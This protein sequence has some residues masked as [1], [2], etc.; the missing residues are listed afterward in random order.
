M[1]IVGRSHLRASCSLSFCC[2]T[3]SC[4][5][6][7]S[8]R[9]CVVARSSSCLPA[10]RRARLGC[11]GSDRPARPAAP[12]KEEQQQPRGAR[13]G[14]ER[15]TTGER[16]EE[17]RVRWERGEGEKRK[18]ECF[19]LRSETSHGLS[20]RDDSIGAALHTSYASAHD[21]C[22]SP[23]CLHLLP[24]LFPPLLPP[25]F[26]P[27][28]SARPARDSQGRGASPLKARR[29]G[30]DETRRRRIQADPTSPTS[31]QLRPNRSS[32]PATTK[33]THI[34]TTNARTSEHDR[35][36]RTNHVGHRPTRRV[37]PDWRN[38]RTGAGTVSGSKAPR[39]NGAIRRCVSA[40][41]NNALHTHTLDTIL[42]AMLC[43][44]CCH[45]RVLMIDFVGFRRLSHLHLL[46]LV[47][48]PN[49][50][51]YV[52]GGDTAR[53]LSDKIRMQCHAMC[54]H[55]PRWCLLPSSLRSDVSPLTIPFSLVCLALPRFRLRRMV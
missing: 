27:V 46:L 35:V 47:R 14:D 33:P 45:C 13:R 39:R 17:E 7:P 53:D 54:M 30:R 28:A 15:D 2:S 51:W 44:C 29:P 24:S 43:L 52:A 22:S 25:S 38:R 50:M 3:L 20:R 34:H 48:F 21:T 31:S 23:C 32:T 19:E 55:H 18:C 10:S 42:Y 26:L 8:C 5:R 37:R 1:R 11:N 12:S 40:G 49:R 9:A 6:P 16:G 41:D 4:V 36:A